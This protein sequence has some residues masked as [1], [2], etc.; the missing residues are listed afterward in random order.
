[1]AKVGFKWFSH[2]LLRPVV[3]LSAFNM[4]RRGFERIFGG[5][6]P[7][8]EPFY[9]FVHRLFAILFALLCSAPAAHA[10][11]TMR[12]RIAEATGNAPLA[13]VRIENLHTKARTFSDSA[14]NFS[15]PVGKDE[16]IEFFAPGFQVL[17]LRTPVGSLPSFHSLVLQQKTISIAEVEVRRRGLDPR[18]DSLRSRE[19][20]GTA[21]DFPEL[22]GL[23]V[24]RHPFS[25][26]S[27]RNR[28]IWAF[29]KEYAVFQQQ[30]FIDYVFNPRL[31]Q[32]LTGLT[33][34]AA[35]RYMLRYRPSYEQ[36]RGWS[37]YDFY[38][39]VK[40]TGAAFIA[41]GG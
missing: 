8:R 37:E 27:K 21:L 10:Q 26:L 16:L 29:Q 40:R 38:S 39:Y 33:G 11:S 24:V 41:R 23:D 1:M 15:L 9:F 5:R 18:T 14:G 2:L 30:K 4:L 7:G 22:T 6:I 12:G 34:E 17:R 25:A 28:Q 13:G 36:I 32:E 20:Y 19:L 3:L 35:Q 31:V